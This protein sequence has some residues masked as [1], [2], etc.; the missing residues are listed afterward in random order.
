M[1]IAFGL[2]VTGSRMSLAHMF[3]QS[4]ILR[5]FRRVKQCL[6]EPG[7]LAEEIELKRLKR[8]PRMQPAV[9]NI[10]GWPFHIMDG[11]SFAHSYRT[12]FRRRIYSFEVAH[13]CPY[14][15]D[16]G[17]NIGVS[18]AWWKRIYPNSR[19]L[20]FEA[21]PDIFQVL[22]KNCGHL[23]DVKLVNA[24][25]WNREGE[26][27]FLA[28]GGEGGHL[29]LFSDHK[30][31]STVAPCV[32]LRTFLTEKCDFLKMDIEGAEVEVIRDSVDSLHNVSRMF[33]EYHSFTSRKQFL[34]ETLSN[35][36][37]AGFRIH[38]HVELHSPLP[39]QEILEFNEKDLGLDLFC[40]RKQAAPD[41]KILK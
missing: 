24:A 8:L 36:E 17:A 27:S 35:L 32:R 13:E 39:F 3:L 33:V 40:F 4:T 15:I 26:A 31:A 6:S 10:M 21:D 29:A 7:I 12:F 30:V 41:I 34:G 28:K 16:C 23:P 11:G 37:N 9:T 19:V 20:A 38:V 25:V 1:E 2:L 18:V 14:I 22:K 5:T